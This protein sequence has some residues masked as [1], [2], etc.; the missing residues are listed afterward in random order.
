SKPPTVVNAV[1]T[2]TGT[3]AST[4]AVTQDRAEAD[5]V[6]IARPVGTTQPDRLGAVASVATPDAPA[7]VSPSSRA[8]AAVVDDR[9]YTAQDRDVV[10]PHTSETVP[11]PTIS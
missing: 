4:R 9:I 7:A 1:R 3:V 8:T 10:P 5:P 6:G 2:G 11:G